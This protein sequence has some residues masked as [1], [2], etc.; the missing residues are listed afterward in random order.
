M[1][2]FMLWIMDK[3]LKVELMMNLGKFQMDFSD[4]KMISMHTHI[5]FNK[6][7]INNKCMSI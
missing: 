2:E 7:K 3:L 4:S 5:D 6:Y 1:T